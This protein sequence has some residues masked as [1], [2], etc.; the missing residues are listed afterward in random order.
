MR[1]GLN[2][3]PLTTIREDFLRLMGAALGGSLAYWVTSTL[4]SLES[5]AACSL[6]IA[7]ASLASIEQSKPF[8]WWATLGA[9]AG[10]ILGTGSVLAD[11][12]QQMGLPD[13]VR[14]RAI[15]VAWLGLA[16]LISGTMLGWSL[17]KSHIRHPRE[18]LKVTS[19]MTTGIFAILVTF[20]FIQAGLD[21]ARALSSKLSSSVTILVAS[22]TVPG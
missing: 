20:K 15:A 1:Q 3:L 11:S 19:A 18:F 5:T 21:P 8:L 13:E 16:G 4:A 22:L 10:S 17:H 6:I 12:A 2:S 14:N 7:L 9:I